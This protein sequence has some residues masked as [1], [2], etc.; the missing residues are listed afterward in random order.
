[1]RQARNGDP[2]TWQRSVSSGDDQVR[3]PRQ[4]IFRRLPPPTVTG[5]VIGASLRCDT[6]IEDNFDFVVTLKAFDEQ[7]VQLDMLARDDGQVS[8]SRQGNRRDGDVCAVIP[9]STGARSRPPVRSLC[10]ISAASRVDGAGPRM[11]TRARPA[12]SH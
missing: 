5:P 4:V 8:R 12:T 7:A 1:L 11:V 10:W 2:S 3:A 9:R 6:A